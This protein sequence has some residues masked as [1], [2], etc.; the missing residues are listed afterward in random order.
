M[1]KVEVFCEIISL[2]EFES[3]SIDTK[4]TFPSSLSFTKSSSFFLITFG[5]V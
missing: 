2:G 3:G 4:S 1:T 5:A